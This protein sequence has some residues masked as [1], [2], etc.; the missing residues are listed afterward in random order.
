MVHSMVA[1]STVSTTQGP[2]I[3]LSGQ[4]GQHGPGLIFGPSLH[5][6]KAC[7]SFHGSGHI[8]AMESTLHKAQPSLL[9]SKQ[10]FG[11]VSK[12]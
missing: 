10:F 5:L 7:S 2:T 4:T 8:Q 6:P 9:Y 12:V 11:L 1:D 3:I